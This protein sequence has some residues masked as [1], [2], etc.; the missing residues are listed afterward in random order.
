MRS[1][2]RSKALPWP[3]SSNDILE[4]RAERSPPSQ[5]VVRKEVRGRVMETM[6]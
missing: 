4:V 3:G 1:K 6:G 5:E 2:V